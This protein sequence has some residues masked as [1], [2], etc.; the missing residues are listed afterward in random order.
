MTGSSLGLA[1]GA[2]VGRRRPIPSLF[3]TTAAF[4]GGNA[5]PCAAPEP[6]LAGGSPPAAVAVPAWRP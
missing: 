5:V 2:T 3:A 4:Q 6:G 1:E